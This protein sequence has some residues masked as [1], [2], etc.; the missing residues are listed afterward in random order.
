MS[1]RYTPNYYWPS[2]AVLGAGATGTVFKGRNRQDG[3]IVAIKSFNSVSYRRPLNVQLRELELLRKM[4]HDNIVKMITAEMEERRDDKGNVT[5]SQSESTVIIMELCNGGS[6][7]SLLEEP[8]YAYGLR[9]QDLRSCIMHISR[10]VNYLR[11]NGIVHRD[12]KPGNIL[13][14]I[15]EN[16]E[17]CYS[18]FKIVGPG[19]KFGDF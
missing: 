3:E 5:G 4:K 14:H 8:E 1:I 16:G 11:L 6:L 17:I 13:R 2:N 18:A 19:S 12:I 7:S 10:G 15:V 9:E